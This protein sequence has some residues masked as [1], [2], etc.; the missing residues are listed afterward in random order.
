MGNDETWRSN[1]KGCLLK[2]LFEL[3]ENVFM[4]EN[5]LSVLIVKHLPK[6]INSGN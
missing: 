2:S 1:S 6:S 5:R 3:S 4:R